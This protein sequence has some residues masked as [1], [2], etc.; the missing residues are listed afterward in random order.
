MATDA[1]G[2][3]VLRGPADRT[4]AVLLPG[5][6]NAPLWQG[7]VHVGV[8]AP[9][10]ITVAAAAR[11]AGSI[12]PLELLQ[13]WRELAGLPVFGALDA[14]QRRL[15]PAVVLTRDEGGARARHPE[16]AV[17]LDDDGAFEIVGAEPGTWRLQVSWWRQVGG[18]GRGS[19]GMDAGA[20]ELRAG[21]TTRLDLDLSHLLPGDLEGVVL[22]NGT[23]MA[24]SQIVLRSIPGVAARAGDR[25]RTEMALT[26]GE[27]RFR[28]RLQPGEYSL[29]AGILGRDGA[30]SLR[31]EGTVRVL[32]GEST[33]RTFH[34][35]S[36]S[37]RVRLLDPRGVAVSGVT[38]ELHD[39]VGSQQW[40]PPT[41]ADGWTSSEVEAGAFT[42]HVLPR[43][44]QDLRA[45]QEVWRAEP[46]N[47]DPFATVRLRLGSVTA[48]VGETT[49]VELRLPSEFEK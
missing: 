45:R 10:V 36:G 8:D 5:P 13:E 35:Q 17:P 12:G 39:A 34:V 46:N 1:R 32:R 14:G 24:A 33:T 43:R 6:G 18:G 4:L 29:T 16:R 20:V 27:G 2:E 49:N 28:A 42:V 38:V 37:V 3:A 48:R 19:D 30:H 41:E 40:M 11:L 31:A 23:P 44:L 7:D 9:L 22:H 26:D 21:E 47:R 15:A 25:G